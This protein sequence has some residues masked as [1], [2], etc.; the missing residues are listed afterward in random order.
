MENDYRNGLNA[1]QK[2]HL[3]DEVVKHWDSY[4]MPSKP[5]Y[6]TAA[7]YFALRC[8]F[9]VTR[10]NLSYAVRAIGKQWPN[11][12]KI[13]KAPAASK[14]ETLQTA[15]TELATSLNAAVAKFLGAIK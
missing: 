10:H 9:E 13:Q 4:I 2:R 6:R 15:Y 8:G 3:Q 14:V 12:M 11:R 7:D 5:D 1:S